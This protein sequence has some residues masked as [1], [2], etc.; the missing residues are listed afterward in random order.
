MEKHFTT[1]D[2]EEH[3]ESEKQIVESHEIAVIARHR[4]D[5]KLNPTFLLLSY[6]FLHPAAHLLHLFE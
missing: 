4:R 3:G 5:R 6:T 1:E 2:T